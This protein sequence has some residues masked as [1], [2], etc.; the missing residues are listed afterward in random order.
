MV[1]HLPFEPPFDGQLDDTNEDDKKLAKLLG[2]PLS[3][4]CTVQCCD[5]GEKI[6]DGVY[7]ISTHDEGDNDEWF[8]CKSC[9]AFHLR[10][11]RCA[12]KNPAKVQLCRYIGN[13]GMDKA[14]VH[15]RV[16]PFEI[17]DANPSTKRFSVDVKDVIEEYKQL[18]AKAESYE[19][20]D[21]AVEHLNA[22]GTLCF[23]QDCT[24]EQEQVMFYVGDLDSYYAGYEAWLCGP[25]G[26][27]TH[28]WKC[29]RCNQSSRYTDK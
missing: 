13:C 4:G 28:H 5:P 11:T 20:W 29:P 21:Y 23:W 19:H 12:V 18:K 27:F 26:G 9:H 1:R 8:I 3:D 25:D 7:C 6:V 2:E 16:P 24:T 17:L 15:V 10:C 22:K 14:G